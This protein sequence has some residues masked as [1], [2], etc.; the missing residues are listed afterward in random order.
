MRL[1]SYIQAALYC[2]SL[3]KGELPLAAW[4]KNY[5][6]ENKKFGSRDRK[7]VSHLCYSYFRLGKAFGEE[8]SEERMVIGLFLTSSAPNALLQEARPEWN[9]QAHLTAEAK[10]AFLGTEDE[11]ENIFPLRPHLSA[12]IDAQRFSLAHLVQPH[13]HLRLRPG[14]EEAVKQKLTKAG[15]PFEQP[16]PRTL[17]LQNNTKLEEVLELDREAVVQDLSSQKVLQPLAT[18][19]AFSG[20]GLSAWDA[21]AASGGKSLL[22]WD[23]YPGIRLTVSDVRSSILR[24]LHQ[25]FAQ[26]GIKEYDSFVADVSAPQFT[27]TKA[28]DLV[29]CDAPCTGSGTW[30]RTPEYLSLFDAAKVKY[31][32]D[33]QKWIGANA[34][35]GLKKGGALLYIT[36]SVFREENEDVAA[37]LQ[38]TTGMKLQS[39]TYFKGWER[40]ADTLFTALFTL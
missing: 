22:L 18:L 13:L 23:T 11:L 17:S 34:S 37:Y 20:E 40:G 19:E 38:Q 5:F 1:P 16:E 36:C 29:I 6:R 15:I 35:K 12:E 25:R 33:L 21:C 14:H 2:I 32:S 30:G 10:L 4:L 24:N 27:M 28:F 26:A 31:Y 8:S 9:A 3:Y 39:T 7:V